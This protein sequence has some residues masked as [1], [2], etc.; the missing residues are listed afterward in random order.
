MPTGTTEFYDAVDAAAFIPT[1]YSREAIIA[2]EAAI[3]Y[4]D[5]VNRIFEKEL[6]Y[7]STLNVPSVSNLSVQSKNT[8]ANAATIFQTI[9]ET[10]STITV[11]TWEY[12]AIAVETFA[13][14]QANRD[15]LATYAPKQGYALGLS[16]DT[17]LNTFNSGLTNNVG[18]LGADPAYEE[19]LRAVQYLDDANAPAEDRFAIV[20][21]ATRVGLL[22]LDQWVHADYSMLNDTVKATTRAASLGSVLGVE[23]VFS[24]NTSGSN[25]A[26]H[27]GIIFQREAI[28]A[29][30]QLDNTVH[31]FFDVN[32]LAYK[33]VVEHIFGT[34]KLR[35]DHGVDWRAA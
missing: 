13:K 29:V 11:G 4:L 31:E 32:Y 16:I 22:K 1:L 6:T 25:A 34:A 10:N 23:T 7:G 14:K 24:T 21:P 33:V 35:D 12:Q 2:R 18:T 5:R 20:S 27:D 17:S 8:S 26:G 9:V 28:A 30:V 3:L 15:L 19:F